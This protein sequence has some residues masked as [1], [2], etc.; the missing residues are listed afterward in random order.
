MTLT[1]PIA[2]ADVLAS[3]ASDVVT[4]INN[5]GIINSADVTVASGSYADLTG[6][7]FPVTNGK[8]YNFSVIG[9][10]QHSTTTGGPILAFSQPGGSC[11]MLVQYAGETAPDSFITEAQATNDGGTGVATAQVANTRYFIRAW[12]V[13][14]CTGSGTFKLRI[15]RNT[16]GTATFEKGFLLSVAND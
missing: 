16:A 7:S 3:F 6:L 8:N 1:A 14:Q 4:A 5:L 12:G 10:Y 15:A 2:G 9:T 11:R 13:Y